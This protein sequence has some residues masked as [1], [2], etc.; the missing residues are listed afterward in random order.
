MKL[1]E[2]KNIPNKIVATFGGYDARNLC[3]HF[4]DNISALPNYFSVDIILGNV[5]NLKLENYLDQ[6]ISMK[7][8]DRV[9][10]H[11]RPS[12]YYEIILI[13][14]KGHENTQDYGNKIL[15]ISDKKIIKKYQPIK[16]NFDFKNYNYHNN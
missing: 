11:N 7:I 16:N 8:Q 1:S 14:G 4:L 3:Q 12:K 10:I 15:N 6:I 9:S 2:F 5:K 13:A